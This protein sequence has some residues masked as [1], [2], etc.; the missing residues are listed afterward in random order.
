MPPTPN[1]Q[2]IANELAKK[3]DNSTLTI[4]QLTKTTNYQQWRV[5]LDSK[6]NS[7]IKHLDTEAIDA[8]MTLM[9]E[10]APSEI[11]KAVNDGVFGGFGGQ[12]GAKTALK[13]DSR[14]GRKKVTFFLRRRRFFF[15]DAL[16]D[17]DDHAT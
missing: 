14:L 1:P 4:E 5:K 13:E 17:D 6:V 11:I 2:A 9:E 7:K 12:W 15:D 16:D 3:T 8:Y 10:S